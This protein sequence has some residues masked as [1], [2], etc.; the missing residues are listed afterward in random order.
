[1]IFAFLCVFSINLNIIK[2]DPTP[3][4][5]DHFMIKIISRLEYLS[6]LLNHFHGQRDSRIE[7]E[8]KQAGSLKYY[9]FLTFTNPFPKFPFSK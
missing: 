8:A 4:W 6:P 2:N 7:D 3:F 9:F 1:V 5:M